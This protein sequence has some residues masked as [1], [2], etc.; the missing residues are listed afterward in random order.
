MQHRVGDDAW[1]ECQEQRVDRAVAD[2]P[3]QELE[4][5]VHAVRPR[6]GVVGAEDVPDH[7]RRNGQAHDQAGKPVPREEGADVHL[8]P[9]DVRSQHR[10]RDPEVRGVVD[11]VL[12]VE[13]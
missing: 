9:V 10:E 1:E 13:L 12:K 11:V 8:L 2:P 6:R 7:E 5:E 3:P 4:D